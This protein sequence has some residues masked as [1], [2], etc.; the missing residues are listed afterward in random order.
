[1][2]KN[3]GHISCNVNF[4][5][6]HTYLNIT[7]YWMLNLIIIEPNSNAMNMHDIAV[8]SKIAE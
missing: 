8:G 2:I 5:Y 7:D 3:L 6:I 4:N 1:M